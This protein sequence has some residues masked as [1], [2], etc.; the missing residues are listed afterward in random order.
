MAASQIFHPRPDPIQPMPAKSRKPAASAP[1]RA[2]AASRA[3]KPAGKES[4]GVVQRRLWL[5][6][7]PK[8]IKAPVIWELGHRFELSTNIRQASVTD[9]VGIVCLEV[10]GTA[11]EVEAGLKW[12]KKL[13]LSVEPV[14]LS[15]VAG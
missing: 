6:Y 5:T 10:Q 7:P 14:E 4:A 2:A 3:V 12:L 15:T 8:R 9:E 11:A 13:G 1:P